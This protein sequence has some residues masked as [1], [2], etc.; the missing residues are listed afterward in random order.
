LGE[1]TVSN[2]QT[3]LKQK[4]DAQTPVELVRLAIKYGV[5]ADQ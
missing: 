3:S 5:I 4:P 2:Y 1:K